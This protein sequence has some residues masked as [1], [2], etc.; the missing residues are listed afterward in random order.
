M[1]NK[2]IKKGGRPRTPNNTW[3][4]KKLRAKILTKY[5]TLR[6]FCKAIDCTDV[7]LYY[8]LSGQRFGGRKFWDKVQ[9]TLDIP[10]CEVYLYQQ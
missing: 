3:A 5:N 6:D 9:K 8:V 7:Q 4:R 10:L 1:S 2:L